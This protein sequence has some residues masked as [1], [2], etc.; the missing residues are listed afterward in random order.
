MTLLFSAGLLSL[1]SL[2][3]SLALSPL[4]RTPSQRWLMAGLF[5]F[6]DGLAV[7]AGYGFGGLVGGLAW[8]HE[9]GPIFALCGGVYC[10]VA[11]FWRTFRADLRMAYL[12]P[13]LMSIDNFA[14]GV[15]IGPSISNLAERAVF[16]GLASGSLAM[17]GL[18]IGHWLRLPNR[19]AS[20]W[21]A[22]FGLIAASVL[23]YFT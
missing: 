5:G 3:V 12:L 7:V 14:Y 11:A 17:L 1:D 8:A 15:G 18:L 16:L 10:L 19:R 22:G 6:C 20:E 9:A 4:I 21:T 23:L 2:I 13:V